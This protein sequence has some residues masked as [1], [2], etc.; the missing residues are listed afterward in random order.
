MG[1]EEV[2]EDTKKAIEILNPI[3]KELN[4]SIEADDNCLFMDDTAIGIACNSTYATLMEA[5]GWIF[6]T[7]YP[8]FRKI[9]IPRDME[10]NIT[11]YCVRRSVL[12]KLK[13]NGE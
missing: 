12:K 1:G 8:K 13:R 2:T 4:I 7:Q 10:K 3:A 11:R 9:E 5:I 6:M